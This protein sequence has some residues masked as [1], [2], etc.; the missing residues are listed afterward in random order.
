MKYFFALISI[1][2]L[3]SCN[4]QQDSAINN[5]F[6]VDTNKITKLKIYPDSIQNKVIGDIQ[7][8][9]DK[10]AF[11]KLFAAY[12]KAHLKNK[13]YHLGNFQYLLINPDFFNDKL[14]Q[15]ALYNPWVET[16]DDLK[17]TI[18]GANDLVVAQYG[19]PDST[20]NGVI[21][22]GADQDLFVWHIGRKRIKI[23]SGYSFNMFTVTLQFE[24]V[25]IVD[26]LQADS[27]KH[28]DSLT[29][30]GKKDI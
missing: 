13:R 4:G 7:F 6:P 1:A 12:Q 29:R 27:R 19:K 14:Y 3:A 10:K 23:I 5:S 9:I 28:R 2:L 24:D 11:D 22:K 16:E 15:V 25:P 17:Q 30:K 8:G 20:Y 26:Q 18:Q 21:S